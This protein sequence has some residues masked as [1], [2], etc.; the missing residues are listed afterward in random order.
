MMFKGMLMLLVQHLRSKR[1]GLLLWFA[2]LALLS[3][4]VHCIKHAK[5]DSSS[6]VPIIYQG[7]RLIV[8]E[9]SALRS[10]VHVEPVHRQA[11]VS[12]VVIPAT[13]Q[14]IPANTVAIF[15]HL[16][17]QIDKIFK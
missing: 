9:H 7:S 10:V 12:T 11:V 2:L 8:P 13:V 17:G 3:L 4:L 16:T 1:R 6:T 5:H 15:P 14:A